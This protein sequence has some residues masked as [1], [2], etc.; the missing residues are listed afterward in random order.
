MVVTRPTRIP[1]VDLFAGLSVAGVLLPEAVAYAS[2]A[3]VPTIHALLA[4]LV[5][6]CVYPV[7][8]TSRFAIVS[9]TSSAAAIFATALGTGGPDMGYALVALT[10]ALFLLGSLLRAGFLGAYVSRPVLRG[11]AWGLAVTIIIKQLPHITG[12]HVAGTNAMQVVAGLWAAAA[13]TQWLSF[14]LGAVAL[15]LWLAMHHGLRHVIFVPQ[16]LVVLV[17]GI[18]ASVWFDLGTHGVALVGYVDIQ[19]LALHVPQISTEHWLRAAEIAPAL[20][21]ILF[22]ESWGSVRS[23]A[24]QAG[25]RVDANREMLAFGSAN[26]L[27]ALLQGLPVG[28]GFSAAAANHASGGRSKWAGVAAAVALALLLWQARG[29][30]AYLPVPV[31]AAVVIAILSHNLWPRAVITGLRLGG[32]AWLA[33]SAAVGV[34]VFGVLFGMLLAVGSSLLLAVRRFAQPQVTELGRLPGTHDFVDCSRHSEAIRSPGVLIVR[35]EEPLFFANAEQVFEVIAQ[36]A[37]KMQP[38]TIVLSLEACDDLDATATEALAEFVSRLQQQRVR[39]ILARV[40]D[41]ARES[42]MRAGLISDTNAILA[43]HWSVDDAVQATEAV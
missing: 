39:L 38:H 40:K 6:L 41:R 15:L 42:L 24:L 10:G 22:A 27:C 19:G 14:Q 2:I 8:G 25:D 4:A 13:Q 35:P 28:A 11:F 1:W 37:N 31:L 20:L 9:P 36:R 33:V 23:L 43:V 16:S 18:A 7:F 12:V 29:W 34:L 3:G 5:G 30:L 17:S 32:D 21:L 26:L